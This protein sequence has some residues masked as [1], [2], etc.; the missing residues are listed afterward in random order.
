MENPA[1]NGQSYGPWNSPPVHMSSHYF[2]HIINESGHMH[3]A[4][5]S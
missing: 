1:E 3:P 2:N 4:S 5:R